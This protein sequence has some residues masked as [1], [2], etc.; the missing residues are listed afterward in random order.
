MQIAR[1]RKEN[2]SA[3]LELWNGVA[4]HDSVTAQIFAEKIWGDADF[5]EELALVAF[6]ADEP[7]ADEP[8]AFAHAVVR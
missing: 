5:D 2:A 3:L 4:T 7:E 8:V 6:E 1:L